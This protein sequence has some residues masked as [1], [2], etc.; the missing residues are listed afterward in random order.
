MK[1]LYLEGYVDRE[2][3]HAPYRYKLNEK[4]GSILKPSSSVVSAEPSEKA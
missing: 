2:S 4:I 1:K 3:N